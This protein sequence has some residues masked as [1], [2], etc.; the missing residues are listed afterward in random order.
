MTKGAK[1]REKLPDIVCACA[2]LRR[3]ARLV[4]QLYDEELRPHLPTSQFALLSAIASRPGCSQATLARTLAFDKT[5]LSRNLALLKRNGW[6]E[7]AAADDQRERG[8]RPTAAG[9]ELL[10]AAR[11]GWRRAQNRLRSKMTAAQWRDMWRVLHDVTDS[12]HQARQEMGD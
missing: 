2:T 3:A 12:A 11:P 1:A 10:T 7:H 8:F 4:T 6:V 5:T 9:E